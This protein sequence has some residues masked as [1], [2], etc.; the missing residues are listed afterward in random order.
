MNDPFGNYTRLIYETSKLVEEAVN[1]M[2]SVKNPV[3]LRVENYA[4]SLN[5]I[6]HITRKRCLNY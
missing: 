2:L 1:A 5:E 4:M 6:P 3:L